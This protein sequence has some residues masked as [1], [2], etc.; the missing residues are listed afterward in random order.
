PPP[1][2]RRDRSLVCDRQP[3]TTTE[4]ARH[5]RSLATQPPRPACPGERSHYD[6]RAL[7]QTPLPRAPTARGSVP[8]IG[9]RSESRPL[10]RPRAQM[11]PSL[12]MLTVHL[13]DRRGR[14]ATAMTSRRRPVSTLPTAPPPTRPL[15]AAAR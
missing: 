8:H 14:M 12:S 4:Q 5:A 13:P 15:L 6:A 9:S 1:P 2:A 3:P 11:P 7:R 10:H